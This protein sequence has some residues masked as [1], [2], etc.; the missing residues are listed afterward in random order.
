MPIRVARRVRYQRSGCSLKID[1]LMPIPKKA[2]AGTRSG[3]DNERRRFHRAA[4]AWR[5]SRRFGWNGQPR[6]AR[7]QR[8][9]ERAAAPPAP[10]S[11]LR[12]CEPPR[13]LGAR[14]GAAPTPGIRRGDGRVSLDDRRRACP[15]ARERR[16]RRRRKRE[17]SSRHR[18]FP[19]AHDTHRRWRS[20]SLRA[21][22]QRHGGRSAVTLYAPSSIIAGAAAR[23]RSARLPGWKMSRRAPDLLPTTAYFQVER[24]LSPPNRTPGMSSNAG[25][26]RLRGAGAGRKPCA[27]ERAEERLGPAS[28]TEAIRS[29][30]ADRVEKMEDVQRR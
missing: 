1:V 18:R 22:S 4:G 29:P 21:F 20:R 11:S 15:R 6:R 16:Q 28:S 9:R 30:E 27:P 19:T 24:R 10:G 12:V 5:P 23:Q 7:A 3:V 13:H 25:S 14:A 8:W 26:C 2:L 17:R